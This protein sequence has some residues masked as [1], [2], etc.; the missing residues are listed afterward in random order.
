MESFVIK[1]INKNTGEDVSLSISAESDAN[2]K[3]KAELQGILVTSVSSNLPP[4]L[5]SSQ[6]NDQIHEDPK[7]KS[8]DS[9]DK[10][11]CYICGP[12]AVKTT[13][14]GYNP[15]CGGLTFHLIMLLCTLGGWA[16]IWAGW[17]IGCILFRKGKRT[18][19]KCGELLQAD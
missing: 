10:G 15:G 9:I 11:F 12:V 2:A 14:K 6:D 18:C 19:M 3:V 7:L 1:G 17:D 16:P 8:G 5:P 13:G 4:K